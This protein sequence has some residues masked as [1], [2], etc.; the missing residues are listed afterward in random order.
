MMEFDELTIAE[1]YE[2]NQ[3]ESGNQ[4]PSPSSS[5]LLLQMTYPR[6]RNERDGI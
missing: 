4:A 5:L 6:E 3:N 1:D 2:T